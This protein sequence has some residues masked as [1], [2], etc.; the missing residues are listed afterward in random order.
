MPTDFS[1]ILKNKYLRA[2]AAATL[3]LVILI[4]S[5]VLSVN[6]GRA[7]IGIGELVK[8]VAGK[9]SGKEKLLAGISESYRAIVW[10][11]RLP[12]ILTAVL[13]GS[14]LAVSGA[15]FQS[16][17]MNPLADSYTMGISTGAA[18]GAA[19]AI[20]LNLFMPGIEL[21]ITL[22]AFAGALLTLGIVVFIAR[23]KGYLNSAN[24]VIAGIIV[25][26]ILSAAISF[27]KSASGEHVAAIVSWLMG[28][29]AAR[30]WKHVAMGFPIITVCVLVCIYFSED[31]NIM[32]A[33]EQA[34]RSLGIDT[35]KLRRIFLVCGAL[36]TA[37]CVSVSGIIGFVGLIVPHM[38]R[39]AIGSD[40]RILIPLSAL[41]GG[42]LLLVADT[43]ARVMMDVEIP[44]GVLTT[45]L[46]G[47]FFIYIFITRNRSLYQ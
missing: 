13:V 34:S 1:V 29:L 5:I 11:I 40:N 45:L 36:I 38:L 30:S 25:S 44:V 42:V 19:M 21:P 28:S 24:L 37:V 46:G 10:D 27:I 26:S 9:I 7:E 14:G 4:L 16:L 31:L 2:K 33:G 18:F 35:Q 12:R 43:G 6:M 3:L 22:C 47:P 8:I 41:M 32:C 15:V 39:F 17:L 20:H 23:I